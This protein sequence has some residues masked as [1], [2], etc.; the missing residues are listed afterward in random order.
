M[1][2]IIM[3]RDAHMNAALERLRAERIRH[4]QTSDYQI[5]VGS[6]NY[7]PGKGT[8]FMDRDPKARP[9][10]GLDNFIALLRKLKD[11]NPRLFEMNE[12]F[13]PSPQSP[14]NQLDI[15]EAFGDPE[16]AAP[17]FVD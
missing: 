11:R 15:R 14:S 1:Q 3:N 5:K 6:Y 10:R 8:I 16:E 13:R 17:S 2:E 12:T 4:T 9:E 7:Y